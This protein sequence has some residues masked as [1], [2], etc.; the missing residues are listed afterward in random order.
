MSGTPAI[1]VSGGAKAAAEKSARLLEFFG[2]PSRVLS[3]AEFFGSLNGAENLRVL[4]PAEIFPQLQPGLGAGKI[5]SV[6]VHGA[7]IFSGAKSIESRAGNFKVSSGLNEFCGAM[8]GVT[9]GGV[10]NSQPQRV[11]KIPGAEEIIFN[12]DGAVFSRCE[13]AGVPVFVSPAEP[14]DLAADLTGIFFDVRRHFAEAVPPALYARW[15]FA[16]TCWQPAETCACLVIDD[17]LLRPSYG[18]VNFDR[19]LAHMERENFST[20][21]AFIPWNWNR[22]ARRT[23]RL[24]NDNSG[25]LSVSI[26]GCDH[27]AG[28]FG[29]ASVARLAWK[30]RLALDRMA[31]HQ[32]RTAVAHDRVMVFP[33]G[34]F[35]AAAMRALKHADFTGTVNS[36]VFN[37]DGAPRKISVGDWWR[38]AVMN[39]DEFPIFTRRYPWAGVENF[40]FDILLGKPCLLV[41]HQNDCFDDCKYVTD[42]VAGVNRLNARLRWTSLGEVVR[43]SFRQREILPGVIE[44]EIFASEAR[45]ENSSTGK[46]TFRVFKREADVNQVGSIRADG[47]EI[48]WSAMPGGIGFEIALEPGGARTVAVSF[49][50]LADAEFAGENFLYEVKTFCRR[51]LCEVRD[52]FLRRKK[53]SV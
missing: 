9:F 5:H 28:E 40:A 23:A 2:V 16:A 33:Q 36:E 30:S 43:R 29:D 4:C 31:R 21:V 49:A 41:V 12:A 8:A 13:I 45:L 47:A 39:F 17:P 52:N 51:R 6:F 50:P 22:S 48:S 38:T 46:K 44:A 18:F 10:E 7:E 1:I 19:L 32:T 14:M 3:V 20:S 11:L 26:H 53:Y 34:V 15:A 24:F 37:V 27:T 25:R 42:C 35:S